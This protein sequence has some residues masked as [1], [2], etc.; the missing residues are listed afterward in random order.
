MKVKTKLRLG[1]GFLFIVIILFGAISLF[2]LN[3][4]SLSA[5][6]ILKDNYETLRFT[7]KMN[8][9]LDENPLPLTPQQRS[10][11]E[12]QLKL[13][14]NNITENGEQEAVKKLR[15]AYNGLINPA[16]ADVQK[17][18]FLRALKQNIRTIEEL[19]MQAIVRK[20]NAA[21]KKVDQAVLFLGLTATFSFLIVFSFIVNFPGF[22]ANPLRELSDGLN[23]I[24]RKNYKQRLN[25]AGNNEFSALAKS[26]NEMAKKLNEWESSNL[27]EIKSEKL[28]IETIIEQMDDAIIGLNEKDDI[29]FINPVAEQILNL[30]EQQ[31]VGYNTK[32][33]AQKNDL[34]NNVLES[35]DNGKLLKIY[36]NQ[37]ESYFQLDS[38]QIILPDLEGQSEKTLITTG[39]SAGK[40]FI[41]RNV[42]QYKELDEAKSN[43]IAT[44]SH[45][46][47][48]PISSIKMSLK[49][50]ED[51]RIG[52]INQEQKELIEHLKNDAGRL[53]K[54]T[55]ELLDLSQIETGNIQL[56][57]SAGMPETVIDYAINAV[58]LQAEQKQVKLEL[59]SGKN[60]PKVF[61]DVD[62]T[63]WVLV[64]F[65][66]NA[67]RYSPEKS[68]II[69]EVLQRGNNV[70]F[71]VKDFGKGIDEQYKKRL[72]DRYF[73]VPTDGQNKSGSGLGL[74]ISKEF[75]EAENGN[76]WVESNVGEG[77]KF[78][79]SL[80]IAETK[81]VI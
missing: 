77:S 49:L 33:L 8:M 29:I 34:L 42:T 71:S 56:N 5:K 23:E 54:I 16:S 63:A 80:P 73:Q 45:E 64:N 67:L 30:N 78:C 48:T 65:L 40:V 20:N 3:E 76:I 14:E 81:N 17:V 13:E 4:I 9:I 15:D 69:I 21:Q 28:R 62:K 19:N 25:T 66:S 11:F 61:L 36:A 24:G 2:Y 35:K 53:L 79:F 59:N 55:S 52:T 51:E 74:A 38:R 72:F 47:K 1:F 10:D 50:L 57:L 31:V 58:K 75:I 32:E 44:V 46:L 60:L 68:K 12:K 7:S 41:L 27:A 43:F 6:I 39:I 22:I 70:E 26:F 18:I 37:K